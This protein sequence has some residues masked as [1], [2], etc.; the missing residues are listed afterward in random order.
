[1]SCRKMNPFMIMLKGQ[2]GYYKRMK[3]VNFGSLNIDYTF[4]VNEIVQPGQT[5]DSFSVSCYPGGKGL[6][7]SI[8][9]ARA[10][11]KVYHAGTIGKDGLFLKDLLEADGVDCSFI[12]ILDEF[13]TGKAF[14]QVDKKGQNSIVLSGGANKANTE[15]YCRSVLEHFEEGD[16]LLLQ[17]EIS[18]I[19]ELIDLAYQKKM[20][21]ILNPSP[22]NSQILEYPLEKVSVFVLNEDEG[23]RITGKQSPDM[24]LQAM[25][26]KYPHAE[27]I[28]TLGE[29]GAIWTDGKEKVFQPAFHVDVIDTTGAGDA[30]TGYVLACL[31]RNES[32]KDSMQKAARA[33]SI[34]VTR[35]GAASAIPHL[36]EL[37]L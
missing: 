5:V 20:R 33:A 9:F 14:I 29:K 19:G 24:V 17:N 11:G 28:L 18:C 37:S 36:A 23:E 27:V 25:M 2:E 3:V 31:S 13:G 21:I 35:H 12:K 7:Q 8:A 6:N 16:W 30:F 15:T 4:H 1:M 22:V 34:A 26:E 32:I 10:G